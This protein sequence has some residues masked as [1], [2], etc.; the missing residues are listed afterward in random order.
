MQF[1]DETVSSVNEEDIQK[2]F[3]E[4]NAGSGYVLFYQAVDLSA[5]SLGLQRREPAEQPAHQPSLS[6]STPQTGIPLSPTSTSSRPSGLPDVSETPHDESLTPMP[7]PSRKVDPPLALATP[8][9]P[10]PAPAAAVVPPSPTT[11]SSEMEPSLSSHSTA[12]S[13]STSPSLAR[14][15]GSLLGRSPPP[16]SASPMQRPLA[17][18]ADVILESRPASDARYLNGGDEGNGKAEREG[19]RG[20]V[21]ETSRKGEDRTEDLRLVVLVRRAQQSCFCFSIEHSSSLADGGNL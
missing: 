2:Y 6:P 18:P 10:S 17:E 20:V 11:T 4:S 19:G 12:N 3:G 9:Q 21:L 16:P 14:S 8:H 13:A 5:A 15:I 1:D 7:S